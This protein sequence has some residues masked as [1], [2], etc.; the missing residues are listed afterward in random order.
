MHAQV[1]L[2]NNQIRQL[3]L[4]EAAKAAELAAII[5]AEQAATAAL[6]AEERTIADMNAPLDVTLR[7]CAIDALLN[8]QVSCSTSGFLLGFTES[9]CSSIVFNPSYMQARGTGCT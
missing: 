4:Q 2:T 1:R 6:A 7:H 3:Q 5:A 9:T 8:L